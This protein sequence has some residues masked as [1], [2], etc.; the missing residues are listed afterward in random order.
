M[1]VRVSPILPMLGLIEEISGA[2]SPQPA[3]TSMM[4]NITGEITKTLLRRDINIRALFME[5]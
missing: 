1:M 3:K 2:F 5:E 4:K